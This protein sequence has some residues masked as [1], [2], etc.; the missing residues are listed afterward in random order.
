VLAVVLRCP[1]ALAP[2]EVAGTLF[3]PAILRVF[4]T[5]VDGGSHGAP[6]VTDSNA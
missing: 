6:S 5:F 3:T 1:A 2:L 4:F